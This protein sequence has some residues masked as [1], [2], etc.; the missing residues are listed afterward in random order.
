V[1]NTKSNIGH[2][3][4][5]AGVLELAGNLPSFVDNM[6]HP[7]INLDEP[8]P[9]CFLSGLVIDEPKQLDKVDAILNNSF[10]M[11]GIN[12]VV[13]VERFA[14]DRVGAAKPGEHGH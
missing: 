2:A 9:D 4:G 3:M 1:N 8:D 11:V 10:G 13:I 6:V 14:R 12:S 7:T 5:A